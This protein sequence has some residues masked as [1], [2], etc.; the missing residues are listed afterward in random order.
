LALSSAEARE[1]AEA[2]VR[3]YCGW[4]V[5]PTQRE[6]FVVHGDGVHIAMLPSLRVTQLHALRVNGR[7]Y[8]AAAIE[9]AGSGIIRLASTSTKLRGVEVE[10]THGF[11]DW[12]LEVLAVIER[13]AQRAEDD[14][15]ALVQVGQVRYATGADGLPISATLTEL[16]KLVLDRY[17]LPSRP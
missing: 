3:S 6:T 17:R 4:H 8:D 2:E 13:L 10:V 16:D 7:D 11:D 9:W 14:P 5:A 1:R 12:P 15:G